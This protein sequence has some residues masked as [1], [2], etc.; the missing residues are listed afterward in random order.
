M[1]SGIRESLLFTEGKNWT[2]YKDDTVKTLGTPSLAAAAFLAGHMFWI[3]Q[4]DSWH[5]LQF[6]LQRGVAG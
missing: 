1:G 4:L 2:I 3:V 6:P 5:P